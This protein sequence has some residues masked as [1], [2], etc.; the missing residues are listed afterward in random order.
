MIINPGLNKN[1]FF[2]YKLD[3]FYENLNESFEYEIQQGNS[4]TYVN[5]VSFND[6]SIGL[7]YS[8]LQF[9]LELN[10]SWI[11]IPTEIS[12]AE[13]IIQKNYFSNL[14]NDYAIE[15]KNETLLFD[16][17]SLKFHNI[18]TNLEFSLTCILYIIQWKKFFN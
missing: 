13:K 15:I 5:S 6:D 4:L 7:K 16:C 9:V 8:S 3:L 14:R 11:I 10:K 17:Q 1:H 2:N 12:R 18:K